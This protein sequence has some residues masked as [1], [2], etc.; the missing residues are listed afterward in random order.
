MI[1][2]PLCTSP[3]LGEAL[4][5]AKGR[6]AA[7][8]KGSRPAVHAVPY[9]G[10]SDTL[11]CRFL[12]AATPEA[13]ILQILKVGAPQEIQ[14]LVSSWDTPADFVGSSVPFYGPEASP[15]HT[16]RAKHLGVT[17]TV[18]AAGGESGR[19]VLFASS[20]DWVVSATSTVLTIAELAALAAGWPGTLISSSPN[21]IYDPAVGERVTVT[22]QMPI[23]K[24][25]L[26][27][28][29]WGE[30]S[31]H[32]DQAGAGIYAAA[33]TLFGGDFSFP[34]YG[35]GVEPSS[36]ALFEGG[37]CVGGEMIIFTGNSLNLSMEGGAVLG[38]SLSPRTARSFVME[39]GMCLSGE[40][41][42]VTLNQGRRTFL[43]GGGSLGG[44][45]G[46]RTLVKSPM[47]GGLTLGSAMGETYP[48]PQ[49]GAVAMEGGIAVGGSFGM[50]SKATLDLQGG[51]CVGGSM[52]QS[53]Y[54]T[55]A[56]PTIDIPLSVVVPYAE[57]LNFP[58]KLT[59][60]KKRGG[61][62]TFNVTGSSANCSVTK[63]P[64]G[65]TTYQYLN[66]DRLVQSLSSSNVDR[67]YDGNVSTA[68]TINPGN[69]PSFN[70]FAVARRNID[71]A[72]KL[73]Y[74][75]ISVQGVVVY[76]TS[77][78]AGGTPAR[79]EV[80]KGGAVASAISFAKIANQ[81][82]AWMP[83]ISCNSWEEFDTISL[84]CFNGWN[85]A[86]PVS[87][88]ECWFSVGLV[89][90]SPEDHVKF[91]D[92]TAAHPTGSYP[93]TAWF[94]Y[95]ATET[96][97]GVPATSAPALGNVQV[98]A[99]K[100]P[101]GY[102]RNGLD[103][104]ATGGTPS[105]SGTYS[106][107][108]LGSY[109]GITSTWVVAGKTLRLIVGSGGCTT[110]GYVRITDSAG[111]SIDISMSSLYIPNCGSTPPTPTWHLIPFCSRTSIRTH[112][113]WSSWLTIDAAGNYVSPT[114]APVLTYVSSDGRYRITGNYDI[115]SRFTPLY[116]NGVC[117][118]NCGY[119]CFFSHLNAATGYNF[120]QGVSFPTMFG[121]IFDI[122]SFEEYY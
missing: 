16:V 19:P 55:L 107:T 58:I 90:V 111:A 108:L 118:E 115:Q 122:R 48:P 79:A 86:Y 91:V 114:T 74:R 5:F 71:A 56:A 83:S 84:W 103:I 22:P 105:A 93:H 92:L 96:A 65:A 98:Q 109:A 104:T 116:V 62:L 23:H 52:T 99:P 32:L 89:S 11:L 94:T 82:E 88:H 95:T 61:T 8:S 39:G 12:L 46:I 80:R 77:V 44:S 24:F 47:I 100:L 75:P 4:A 50:M 117:T 1:L 45:F 21:F 34:E 25:T 17:G 31:F 120:V 13:D 33:P 57:R 28:E 101:L 72:F 9:R 73:Q 26:T 6:Y 41:T 7:L 81:V 36:P 66:P 51:A 121:Y 53:S 67:C 29:A 85:A 10:G 15:S 42:T 37:G 49:E 54:S 59:A 20:T 78:Y 113:Q 68:A 35:P 87:I 64:S 63:Y 60:T 76:S 112:P 38:G 2:Q 30:S 27:L 110:S 14:L 3:N 119:G 97:G 69:Y 102:T 18:I 43:D 70:Y 106:F 40:I